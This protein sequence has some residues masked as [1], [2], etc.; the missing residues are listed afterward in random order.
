MKDKRIW[1]VIGCILVIGT[2]VT[3]YTKYYVR[4]QAAGVEE[5]AAPEETTAGAPFPSLVT[6]EGEK[7]TDGHK[8]A[9]VSVPAQRSLSAA[10]SMGPEQEA[11]PAPEGIPEAGTAV[12]GAAEET[13]ALEDGAD[14]VQIYSE[15]ETPVEAAPISPLTGAGMGEEKRNLAIDYRQRLEDLDAQ[16][17]KV[18]EQETDSNVYSIKTSAETELKMWESELNTI[19]NALLELLPQ[20]DAAGLAAEQREWMKNRDIKAAESSGR[21]GGVDR[22]GYAATLVSVTRDRA[23]ELAGRYEEANGLPVLIEDESVSTVSGQ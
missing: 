9:D 16:I 2:G 23:Y 13:E 22:I 11:A 5:T 1:I 21:S 20:E 7:D 17:Q 10:P 6:E 4:S 12:A 3:H 18:R 15:D 19:Y 14:F 8:A